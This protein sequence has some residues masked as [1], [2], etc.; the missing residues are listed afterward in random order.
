PPP[1][2]F[3]VSDPKPAA[4]VQ[5]PASD[6]ELVEA[7]ASACRDRKD[8]LARQ[9]GREIVDRGA[10]CLGVARSYFEAMP[11]D[12]EGGTLNQGTPLAREFHG[13]AF[14]L[15]HLPEDQVRALSIDYLRS[16]WTNYKELDEVR[17]A[18]LSTPAGFD[19]PWV[20]LPGQ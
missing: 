11:L 15:A 13:F 2:P 16:V 9:L 10:A 6:Q 20:I 19:A 3:R 7:F 18:K 1:L 4:V 12:E 5:A 8:T 17:K 14:V